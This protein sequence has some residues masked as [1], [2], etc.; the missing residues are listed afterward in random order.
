VVDEGGQLVDGGAGEVTIDEPRLDSSAL[1][2]ALVRLL[3]E[4]DALGLGTRGPRVGHAQHAR[5]RRPKYERQAV[6]LVKEVLQ[7]SL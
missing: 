4:V 6:R 5:H 7:R 1:R 2:Q 3:D